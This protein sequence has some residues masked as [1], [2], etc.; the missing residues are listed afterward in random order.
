MAI[1]LS[2]LMMLAVMIYL[3]GSGHEAHPTSDHSPVIPDR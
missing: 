3:F 1:I 2:V